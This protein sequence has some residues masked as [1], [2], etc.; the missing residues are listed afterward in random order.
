MSATALHTANAR[1][2]LQ[3]TDIDIMHLV[4]ISQ[5]FIAHHTQHLADI[6]VTARASVQ[7][8]NLLHNFS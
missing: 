8:D 7:D 5:Q 1:V 2:E 3:F 6:A 4:A